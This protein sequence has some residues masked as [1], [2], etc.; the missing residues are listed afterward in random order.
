MLKVIPTRGIALGSGEGVQNYSGQ[1]EPS[2][3]FNTE[4]SSFGMRLL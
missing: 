4:M 2:E 1:N 3:L